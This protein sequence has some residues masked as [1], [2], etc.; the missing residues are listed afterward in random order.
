MGLETAN[1]I[2]RELILDDL[3]ERGWFC[4]FVRIDTA[5][6]SVFVFTAHRNGVDHIVISDESL[7]GVMELYSSLMRSISGG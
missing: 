7:S 1:A 5:V 6:G 2:C 4:R 3:K